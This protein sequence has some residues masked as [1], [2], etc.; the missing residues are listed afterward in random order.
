MTTLVLKPPYRLSGK[1]RG[2]TIFLAGSI[3]MGA[4]EPW[5]DEIA[6]AFDAANVKWKRDE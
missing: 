2:K 3:E 6:A 1:V 4:A 5:Q